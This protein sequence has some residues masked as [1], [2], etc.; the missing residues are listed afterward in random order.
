MH[1]AIDYGI[2]E[3]DVSYLTTGGCSVTMDKNKLAPNMSYEQ[4]YKYITNY[5]IK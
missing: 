2:E 4:F 1:T 5:L 3:F